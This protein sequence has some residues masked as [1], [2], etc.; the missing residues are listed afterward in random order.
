MSITADEARKV[1]EGGVVKAQA[2]GRR[3]TITVVDAAGEI[4]ATRRMDGSGPVNFDFSYGLAYTCAISKRSGEEAAR[5]GE[6]SAA[7]RVQDRNWYR[8]E[9]IM[10]G[11]RMMVAKGS[12]PL[13][14]GDEVIG[15]VGVSGAPQ[16]IDLEVAG[17]GVA[18]L[19]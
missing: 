8:A 10:R 12:L 6:E 16:E 15:G 9:S 2:L 1:V 13:K 5:A 18:A 3:I 14:R 11:G 7:G 17:A 19:G 4:M